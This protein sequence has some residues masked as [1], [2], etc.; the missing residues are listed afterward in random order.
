MYL[1]VQ[2]TMLKNKDPSHGF[3]RVTIMFTEH[4]IENM[5]HEF[6]KNLF[7]QKKFK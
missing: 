2:E 4:F 3:T 7:E 1:V 5:T 6:I